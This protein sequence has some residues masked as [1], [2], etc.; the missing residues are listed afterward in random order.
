[1]QHI[2]AENFTFLDIK[3]S[4]PHQIPK[5]ETQNTFY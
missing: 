4:W 1:M 5:H 2:E 3:M